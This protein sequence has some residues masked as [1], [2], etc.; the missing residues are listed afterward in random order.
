M[1]TMD[2]VRRRGV[3][4]FQLLLILFVI[5]LPLPVY[6][7]DQCLKLVFNEYC[8]G[9]GAAALIYRKAPLMKEGELVR[10]VLGYQDDGQ[11]TY[12]FTHNGVIV[13]VTRS[14]E[15]ASKS[16]YLEYKKKLTAIYGKSHLLKKDQNLWVRG[17]LRLMLD[18][19]NKQSVTLSYLHWPL[20]DEMN[21]SGAEGL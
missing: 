4:F 8:L 12:V 13:A 16:T 2:Y 3:C 11:L 7:A 6:S 15:P 19:S 14:L 9:G 18:W 5:A 17:D 1:I 20:Y 21:T 10:L